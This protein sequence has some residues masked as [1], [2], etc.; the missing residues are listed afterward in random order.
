M[1]IGVLYPRSKAHPEIMADFVD[2]IKSALKH[3]R[4]NN[5]VV[6]IT[7]SIGYG[8]AE[9]EVYEKAE[10]LLSLEG[11]DILVAYIDQRIISILEPLMHACGKLMIVVN[12]GA[13]YPE[14][15]V[16]QP[17]IIYLTQHHSLLCWLS[18]LLAA[19]N[20]SSRAAMATTFYDGGY[21]HIAAMT[22]NYINNGGN[23][24]YNYINND[25][26]NDTF[27][28]KPLIDFLSSEKDTE[29]LLCVFDA[30]PAS[31]FYDR[32]NKYEGSSRL[33]LFVS[34]MMLEQKAWQG[35]GFNFSIEGYLPYY[36]ASENK[37]NIEFRNIFTTQTKREVSVFALQGWEA[38]L[39]IQEIIN[40]FKDKYDD[41]TSIKDHLTTTIIGS[42][43]GNLKLD[44]ETHYFI[45]PFYKG[46][47][48]KKSTDILITPAE[49]IEEEWEKFVANP[50]I[51]PSSG[52]TNTYLCY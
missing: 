8:G 3:Y 40:N 51:G 44:P 46:T 47:I 33:H 15:W 43:R 16:S 50:V 20:N 37:T 25:L 23:I 12:P 30:K 34:P 21:L 5:D 49:N 26:Y 14:N 32:L 27:Q 24:C 19:K 29:N 9:K 36:A 41:G 2:G 45:A 6:L 31:L 1:K 28:I 18:G 48:E 7:E 22:K 52:W 39:I 4:L 38:A 35:N 11:A 17:N 13:N 42:P 10:K